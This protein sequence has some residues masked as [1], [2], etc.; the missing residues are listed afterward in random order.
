MRSFLHF[1]ISILLWCLFGYYWHLVV[2]R[3]ISRHSLESLVMLSA[4]TL[5]VLAITL[6]W[7]AHNKRIASRGKRSNLMPAPPEPFEMDNLQRPIL[8][9]PIATLQAARLVVIA[10]DAQGNKVYSVAE[11][12]S[13]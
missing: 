12:S 11:G 7:I 5:L 6:W 3:Q 4:F 8:A 13:D 9:P 2:Q 1:F 10:V